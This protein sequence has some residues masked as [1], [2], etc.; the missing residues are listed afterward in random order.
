MFSYDKHS[1]LAVDSK[2]VFSS[3][4]GDIT[5][6]I[7]V[8]TTDDIEVYWLL[9]RRAL[10]EN[11]EVFAVSYEEALNQS[12]DSLMEKFQAMKDSDNC[13]VGVFFEETLVGMIHISRSNILKMRHKAALSEMYIVPEAR[14]RRLGYKLMKYAIDLVHQMDGI[15]QLQL[16]VAT[17]NAKARYLYHSLGFK[18]YGLERHGLKLGSTYLDG[19]HMVLFF[20]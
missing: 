8:L 14:G 5:P 18:V 2:K 19:A 1:T 3:I 16:V 15:E 9:R 13:V 10:R 7:R 11:P 12:L 4:I 17:T 6:Q 20:N